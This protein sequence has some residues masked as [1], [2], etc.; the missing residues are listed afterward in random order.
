MLITATNSVLGVAQPGQYQT[1]P[2]APDGLPPNVPESA[3]LPSHGRDDVRLNEF[4]AQNALFV[5]PLTGAMDDWLEL[6]NTGTNIVSLAGWV[7]TDTLDSTEPPVPSAKS[8]KALTI[9]RGVHLA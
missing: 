3:P 9:P 5:N 4:M 7:V 6:Y 1:S 2:D 8:S